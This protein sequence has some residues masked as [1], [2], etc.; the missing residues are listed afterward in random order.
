VTTLR[1]FDSAPQREATVGVKRTE[2]SGA[3]AR[4]LA[5]ARW[6]AL[7]LVLL[8]LLCSAVALVANARAFHP[9]GDHATNELLTRDV[10]R[11]AVLIGPYARDDWNHLG[12]TYYYLLAVPYRLLGSV[13]IGMFIGA[14]LVNAI[15]LTAMVVV[16]GRFGGTRLFFLTALGSAVVI[17]ALGPSFVR[18]PWN[19]YL[20]VLPFGLFVMLCWATACG[21]RW[22]LPFA[23]GVASFAMQTHIAFLLVVTPLLLAAVIVFVVHAAR[24]PSHWS[25]DWLR[26]Y[27]TPLLVALLVLVVLWLP[28]VIQEFTHTPGNLTKVYRYFR[29]PVGAT[30]SARQGIRLVFAQFSRSPEWL[31]GPGP[32]NFASEPVVLTAPARIPIFL[33]AFVAAFIVAL[34]RREVRTVWFGG[35]VT[36]GLVTTVFAVQRTIGLAYGYRLRFALVLGMLAAVFVL[37]VVTNVVA[38]RLNAS[39]RACAIVAVLVLL[40][41]FAASNAIAAAQLGQPQS[42]WSGPI[43]VLMPQIERAL[44][45]RRGAVILRSTSFGGSQYQSGIFLQLERHGALVK[46]DGY[47]SRLA[48]GDHRLYRGGPTRGILTVSANNEVDAPGVRPPG[49]LIA[50]WGERSRITHARL[51]RQQ[52]AAVQRCVR[53]GGDQ[54]TCFRRGTKFVPGRAVGV[55]LSAGPA[56][57]PP[58]VT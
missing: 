46:I 26:R 14:L 8:P 6:A 18:D 12:P 1:T 41:A 13:S 42:S 48:Y 45:R 55:S 44:P 40:S 56:F 21:G 7:T 54:A 24:A 16:A 36:L 15:A 57:L 25:R 50:Y 39:S 4:H 29:H 31:L 53:Q 9:A 49:R 3:S 28:P 19:P 23:T 37:W 17:A 51:V 58:G 43:G 10:G 27:G 33:V 34:R 38:A 35:A 20:P 2:T 22:T 32:N 30:H 11:H 52:V 5:A 47:P